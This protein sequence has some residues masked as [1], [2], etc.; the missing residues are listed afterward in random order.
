V[1]TRFLLLSSCLSL[2]FFI[3]FWNLNQFANP[4]WGLRAYR[5]KCS[6]LLILKLDYM[7]FCLVYY[8]SNVILAFLL[9]WPFSGKYV[10]FYGTSS[11]RLLWYVWKSSH[12]CISVEIWPYKKLYQH[13]TFLKILNLIW[14]LS[15][16]ILHLVTYLLINT[17]AL[18]CTVI[19]S[20]FRT[21]QN[22]L[23]L[24]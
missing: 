19:T 11:L 6:E 1:Y 13:E 7:W 15:F 18:K 3:T 5:F 17:S 23:I 8:S 14:W 2:F 9:I 16:S 4:S 22:L 12:Y 21:L 24:I 10:H 20:S